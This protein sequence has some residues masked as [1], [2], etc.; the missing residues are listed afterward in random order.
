MNL[1]KGVRIDITAMKVRKQ[2]VDHALAIIG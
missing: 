2:D 1:I